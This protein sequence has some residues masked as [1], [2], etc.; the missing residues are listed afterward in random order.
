MVK[1]ILKITGIVLGSIL[2]TV[3]LVIGVTNSIKFAIYSSYYSIESRLCGNPGLNDGYIPQGITFLDGHDLVLTSGYFK[4]GR[5]SRMYVTDLNDNA[6]YVNLTTNGKDYTGH[7]GGVAYTN[8]KVYLVNANKVFVTP[9]EKILNAKNGDTVDMSEGIS[10]NNKGSF[11]FTNDTSLFVGEFN[12][13][14]SN[15][16]NNPYSYNGEDHYAIISEYA[17]DDFTKPVRIYSIVD[18]VQG[19]VFY[20]NKIILSTSWAIN[21]S[22]YY[23]YDQHTNVFDIG[24]TFDNVPVYFIGGEAKEIRGPAF[25]QGLDVYDGKVISCSEAA[26][27]AYV[28]GKFFNAWD[29]VSLDFY[30]ED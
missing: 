18:K 12:N 4:D 17:I 19:C 25:A 5:N 16:T 6:Y 11:C 29:I 2:V 10:I 9:L 26:S 20:N 30:K 23:I 24:T 14:T 21:D 8:D 22:V 13:G 3:G 1:K 28:V 7:A 15:K 27:N